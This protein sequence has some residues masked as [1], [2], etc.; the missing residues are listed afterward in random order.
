MEEVTKA[1]TWEAPE[2]HHIE[3]KA[4]W[5]WILGILAISGSVAAFFFSNFLL[6]ILILVA[7]G[8]MA[9]IATRE[10]RVIPFAVSTRG[11]KIDNQS[12]P[13]SNLDSYHID[14]ADP[15]GPQ[16]LIKS[17][18]LYSPLMVMPLPEEYVD[19]IEELIGSRLPEEELAEPLL[20]KVLEFFGF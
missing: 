6:S 1:I 5:F 14:E 4:D 9:L 10:P 17:K 7:A 15:L 18:N 19:D 8:S 20:H 2:H 12:Y 13:Y 16:L 11:I 3:K